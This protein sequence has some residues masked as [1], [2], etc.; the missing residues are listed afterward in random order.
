VQR[1]AVVISFSAT[2]RAFV[3]M[4]IVSFQ[5]KSGHVSEVR[6]YDAQGHMQTYA[7]QCNAMQQNT[8]AT[9]FPYD[10]HRDSLR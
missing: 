3:E 1:P 8:N 5:T 7:M 2:L 4:G 6:R 10:H 9:S